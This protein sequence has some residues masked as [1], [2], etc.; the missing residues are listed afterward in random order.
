MLCL[1]KQNLGPQAALDPGYTSVKGSDGDARHFACP[2][3]S[4]RVRITR[5]RRVLATVRQ[6]DGSRLG[7]LVSVCSLLVVWE[8]HWRQIAQAVSL[9]ADSFSALSDLA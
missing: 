8:V 1:I 4:S 7:G 9:S 6:Q 2:H 5:L 3:A